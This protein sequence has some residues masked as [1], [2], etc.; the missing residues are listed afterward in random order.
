MLSIGS[1]DCNEELG[2]SQQGEGT[3]MR[4][5]FRLLFAVFIT[6][7][8][9]LSGVTRAAAQE[10]WAVYWYIC[11]SDLETDYKS[12]SSNI[13]DMCSVKLPENVKVIIQTGGAKKW[14]SKGIPS[15]ALARYVYDSNGFHEIEKLP[16]SNMGSGAVL[17]DFLSFAVKN[18]PADHKVL[19]FWNH[20]SGSLGGVCFDEKYG[21]SISLNALR[22]ALGGVFAENAA[23]PP[24]DLVCFDTCLMATLE[25]ANSLYGYTGYLAASQELMPDHGIDYAAWLGSIAKNPAQDGAALGK[26]ICDSYFERCKNQG[27][28]DT[29]TFSVVDL[30][31]LPELNKAVNR[32][33]EEA[34]SA[35]KANPR[36]FFT[37][38]DRVANTVERYGEQGGDEVIGG[39]MEMVDLGSL[40]EYMEGVSSAEAVV[41]AVDR[42]VICKAKGKYRRYGKGLSVY[43]NLTGTEKSST[44]YGKLIGANDNFSALHKAMMSGG[45]SDV[46]WYIID[47]PPTERIPVT[48]DSENIATAVLKPDLLNAVSLA[49]CGLYIPFENDYMCLGTDDKITIDWE[50]GVFRDMFDGQWPALN[51]HMLPMNIVEQYPDY[52]LYISN[53][54]I[55]GKKYQLLSGFDMEQQKFEI[56]GAYRTLRNGMVDRNIVQLHVGDKITPLFTIDSNEKF[57]EGEAFVLE[58]EPVL[59]DE[60]LPDGTYTFVFHFE[61]VHNDPFVSDGVEMF[62]KNGKI[63]NI[64]VLN[65]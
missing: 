28:Q 53:I 20:G 1:Q 9:L 43:Y 31:A 49:Y 60:P 54:K 13:A 14:H 10:T 6:A 15:N 37:A 5:T 19:V 32:L 8:V 18:Y 57:V 63:E 61:S 4:K 52:A 41:N 46:P 3:I 27:T 59:K 48:L 47:M 16:D 7:G 50:K 38:L 25:T 56:L 65:K 11:G 23:Q 30:S 29:A 2:L 45:E 55:N 12:A 36:Y 21:T 33:G 44:A 62:V 64:R 34:L 58:K 26:V 40:A 42:A 22:V 39:G 51:G 24:I 35:S 17:K